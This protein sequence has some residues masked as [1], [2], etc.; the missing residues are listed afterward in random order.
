MIS[1]QVNREVTLKEKV[2][3][4]VLKLG[5]RNHGIWGEKYL[6]SFSKIVS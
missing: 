2:E 5:K 6:G 3:N 4:E 1:D